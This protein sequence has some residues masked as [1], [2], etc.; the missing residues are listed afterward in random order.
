MSYSL[1]KLCIIL[2][3]CVFD[4]KESSQFKQGIAT[5]FKFVQEFKTLCMCVVIGNI[6]LICQTQFSNKLLQNVVLCSN[7]VAF[8][9]L[10]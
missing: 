8:G 10:F 9:D 4:E 7:S 2:F 6:S 5:I 1:N 3:Y